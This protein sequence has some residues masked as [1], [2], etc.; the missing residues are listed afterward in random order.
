MDSPLAL[1]GFL[2]IFH[3]IGAVALANGLRAIWNWLRDKERGLGNGLFFVLWGAMFGCMPL[4]FGLGLAVD[5]E[6]GTP[7]V[8][9]GQAIVCGTAFLI[10]LLFWDDLVDW[11]RPFLHPN[12]FL[13]GFGGIFMLVGAAVAGF[14]IRDDI[15]FGLMFGGVFTF[16]GGVI[17]AIGVWSLLKEI[18]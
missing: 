13:V 9:L 2:S 5:E 14:T 8:L 18:A 7:L 17:F 6:V 4:A 11:V 10:A 12:M 15:L 16:V 3:V 1:L